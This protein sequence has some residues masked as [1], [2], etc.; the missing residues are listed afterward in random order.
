M[1]DR[2]DL[3]DTSYGNSELPAYRE[4]RRE[5]YG[6]DLG[7]TS[8]ATAEEFQLIA[9][10]LEIAS[11]SSV[12]EIGSGSGGCAIYFARAIGCRVTGLDLNPQGIAAANQLADSQGVGDTVIFQQHD[13]STPLPFA[14]AAFDAIYSNDAFC[15][16]LVR[17][18]LLRECRRVLKPGGR[19][20]FSDALVISGPISDEEI[21]TRSSIGRYLFVPHGENECMLVESGFELLQ[22][23]DTSREAAAVAQRWHDARARRRDQLVPVEG[24]R[25]FVGLQR[26]LDCVRTL[27]GEKRLSRFRYLARRPS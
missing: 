26:F 9:R 6:Q 25:N 10:Q 19:L 15:H 3:Y 22:S 2:V 8:W 16:L 13:A 1:P 5:T 14:A 18:A 7:Q 24:E 21:A 4:I 12:L 11:E 20:L 23:D 17:P 27:T